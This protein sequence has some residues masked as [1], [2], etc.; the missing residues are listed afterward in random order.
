MELAEPGAPLARHRLVD[1][2]SPDEARE[3]IGR[4]FCP[5]VLSPRGARPAAFHA[6]HHSARQEDY[7]INFVAYGAAVDIDPGELRGFFLLQW[8]LTG[9]ARVRC[10]TDEVEAASGER[11]SLLSPTL[12]THMEW[13]EG[14]EKIIALVRREAL[15]RQLEALT[16]QPSRPVEFAAGVAMQSALGRQLLGHLELMT[17]AAEN[18][19]PRAYQT[20][21]RDALTTLLLTGQP[22]NQSAS[23][24]VPAGAASPGAVRRAEAYIEAH[25]CETMAMEEIARAAGTSLRSLQETFRKARGATLSEFIQRRRLALFRCRLSDPLAPASI[26]EIAFS[27][28]LGHLGR[29]AAAYRELYGETPRETLRRR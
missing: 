28:G 8:P 25:L 3:A 23:L 2:R 15:Q 20:L 16:G 6:R 7:S 1:T 27:I 29:A 21:L 26:T 24:S 17:A 18:G 11:A 5:H 4:I 10:G 14:C 9:S 12:P 22:H 19:A 13:R